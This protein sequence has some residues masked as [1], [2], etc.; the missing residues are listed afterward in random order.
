M[1]YESKYTSFIHWYIKIKDLLLVFTTRIQYT[2]E[3]SI[4]TF[5]PNTNRIRLK[6]KQINRRVIINV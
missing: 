2:W 6:M 5:H 1:I 3:P 4:V